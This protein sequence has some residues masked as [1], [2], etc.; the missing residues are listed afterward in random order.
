LTQHFLLSPAARGLSIAQVCRLTDDEAFDT[1]ERLR[2]AANGGEPFCP[3]CGGLKIYTLAET[4]VRW[5]CAGCRRKFSVTSQTL[6]HSRKLSIRDYLT[7]I[8]LFANGVKGTSALQTSRNV[9]VNPKSAFVLLHKLREAMAAEV[10]AA[11]EIGGPGREAEIDGAYFGHFHPANRKADR[12]DRRAESPRRKV[13]VIARERHGRA[14]PR[15][16]Q[17]EAD[18]VSLIRRHVASGT[19]VHADESGA[20]NVL[21]ASYPM[22][23]VNH[24]IEYKS[25][26]GASTNWAESYF[27]RL[28]RSEMGVHH[29]ISSHLLQAYA[30]ECAYSRQPARSPRSRDSRKD[31]RRARR[32]VAIE[33]A[34]IAYIVLG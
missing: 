13:V 3:S 11:D 16:V 23:R 27:S 15:T 22:K 19:E 6:F 4:P 5:K 29:R 31:R 17:R 25:E 18:G 8:A 2:F 20:W 14:M 34:S 12:P 28:R 30:D 26:D 7:V 1:F 33:V 32:A 21:L 9:N 24:T 10:H